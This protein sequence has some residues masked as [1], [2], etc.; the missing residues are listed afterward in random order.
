MTKDE[1]LQ[2][3]YGTRTDLDRNEKFSAQPRANPTPTRSDEA[4]GGGTEARPLT[5]PPEQNEEKL[6]AGATRA[7]R[8]CLWCLTAPLQ[9]LSA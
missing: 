7:K 1:E 3:S 2:I 9:A 5:Q 4:E 8:S 6:E